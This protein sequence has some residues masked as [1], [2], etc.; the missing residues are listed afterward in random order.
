MS[1]RANSAGDQLSVA[2]T[3]TV[4]TGAFS[5]GC[6]VKLISDL[7]RNADLFGMA[8]TLTD[9]TVY[10]FSATDV[11]GT[12]ALCFSSHEGTIPGTAQQLTVG[13]WYWLVQSR[14]GSN[15]WHFR[16]F[17]DTTSTTPLVTLTK[18][19]VGDWTT[20]AN[21]FVGQVFTGESPDAEFENHKLH[22]DVEWTDAQCRTESQNYDIQTGGGTAFCSHRLKTTATTIDGLND[23][24]GNG[25]NLANTGFVNGAST[26]AQ[27]SSGA[28][29][30]GPAGRG[31]SPYI[32][33]SAEVAGS[34]G[35]PLGPTYY[36]R[37]RKAKV[38]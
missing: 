38:A 3:M 26:P 14:D 5:Q 22:D 31:M 8:D 18:A 10:Q 4:G 29:T 9:P 11:D 30:Y 33:G 19:A 7:N 27:L 23:N 17:D 35:N 6:W 16:V 36:W 20:F 2:T 15:N 34:P 21:V 13:T 28:V 24:T 37:R 1:V 32:F 25:R 12:G